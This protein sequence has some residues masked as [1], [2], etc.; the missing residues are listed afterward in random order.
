METTLIAR[1]RSEVIDVSANLDTNHSPARA[2]TASI[3]TS[4]TSSRLHVVVTESVTTR[5]ALTAAA[6]PLE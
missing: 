1:M 6:V 3:S 2:V 4:A 5:M